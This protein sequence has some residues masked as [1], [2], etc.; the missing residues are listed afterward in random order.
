MYMNAYEGSGGMETL[1]FTDRHRKLDH[2]INTNGW[3][4]QLSAFW[5]VRTDTSCSD[6]YV[7]ALL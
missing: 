1:G 4:H 7:A 6:G 5:P 3:F 2:F